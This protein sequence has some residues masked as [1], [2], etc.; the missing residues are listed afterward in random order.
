MSSTAAVERRG[1]AM[2]TAVIAR[3]T[4]NDRTSMLHLTGP[5]AGSTV[6]R[7]S[8]D[9]SRAWANPSPEYRRSSTSERERA[10]RGDGGPKEVLGLAE[11]EHPEPAPR[12]SDW[13]PPFPS[14]SDGR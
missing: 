9:S 6:A 3:T 12:G 7:R 10:M 5:L 2:A 4:R 8:G 14:C 11:T 1:V 13:A